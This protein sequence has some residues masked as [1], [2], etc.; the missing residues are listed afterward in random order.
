MRETIISYLR[1]I[2]AASAEMMADDL[3]LPQR[4]LQAE[5]HRMDDDG[6]VLMSLGWYRL[7]EVMRQRL[8]E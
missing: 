5:L 4:D 8:R 3:G 2:P 6:V 1:V 7:S